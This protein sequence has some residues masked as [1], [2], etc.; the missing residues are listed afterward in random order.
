MQ[1]LPPN[2]SPG[3][4]SVFNKSLFKNHV[5][6]V[7]GGGTGIGRCIAHEL[8]SLGAMVVLAARKLDQLT[9]TAEEIGLLGGKCDVMTI[10]IRDPA[11]AQQ[12]VEQIVAKHGKLTGLVNNA[13]GQFHSPASKMSPKGFATVVDLNL[14]G[15]FNLCKAAFDG[16]MGEHGG[17]IVNIVAECRNGFPGMVH[18]GA[19]RSGIINMTKTLAVEWGPYNG[20]RVNCV[21]PGMILSSGM[22]NYPEKVL[23]GFLASSWMNPAGR[24]GTESEIA[25]S[26][27]FLLSPAASY[28]NG[29][30][31]PVDG[32]SSLS[33]SDGKGPEAIYRR[34]G[35]RMK[36]YIGWSSESQVA[37]K[38][39]DAPGPIVKLFGKYK[40]MASSSKL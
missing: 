25:A 5:I 7:T 3:Y 17:S 38:E 24:M 39:L 12:L 19:A 36:P 33:K 20:I 29:I 32:G 6:L 11:Q 37:L 8:A 27:V 31:L 18:T 28:I 15:T 9:R 1:S 16:Y 22:K 21:A 13:G 14:V 30:N 10:N 26:V 4:K 35:S 2:L 34:E 23:D 40:A